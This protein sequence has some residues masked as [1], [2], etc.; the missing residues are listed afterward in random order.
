MTRPPRRPIP[1]RSLAL[2]ALLTG[3]LAAASACGGAARPDPV[4]ADPPSPVPDTAAR[5]EMDRP[6][7]RPVDAPAPPRPWLPPAIRWRPEAPREGDV[8]ALHLHQPEAGRRPVDVRGELDGRPVRFTRVGEDWFGVASAPI[9]E[10]GAAELVL[11]FVLGPDS[12]VVRRTRLEIGPRTF[13][14]TR[15]SVEP[16]YSSPSGEAL[17]RIRE[18]RKLVTAVLAEAT[19]GWLPRGPFRR[20]RDTRM[21]SPFGQRR[22]F[23]DEL[24]SRHTG[25]DLAGRTGDPVRAAG[26]GRVAL[27]RDLYF[28]GNAV[29]L[30]HG[31]G[32]YTGYFHLSEIEVSEGDTVRAGELVG[33]VGATG[34]VTGPHLHWSAW[35]HGEPLDARSLLE[36]EVPSVAASPAS[37]L[38]TL[39]A[40][41]NL[42]AVPI[43]RPR[44]PDDSP[45]RGD[46]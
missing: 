13:P 41:D 43:R 4:A 24:Q 16:R 21:T 11:R 10:A 40:P 15:L 28:A 3:L 38:P 30:D 29:Y 32:L 33:R 36:L 17:V 9:G 1:L 25:V 19:G 39:G 45:T 27:A 20:P 14:A 12:S 5:D 6:D 34:R 8:V 42:P 2:A 37:V 26:R 35:V 46:P 22:V 23:N 44:L 31:L 7:L 18:E